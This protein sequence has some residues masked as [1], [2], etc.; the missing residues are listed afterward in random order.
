MGV[1]GGWGGMVGRRRGSE[2]GVP[3]GAAT[4][5]YSGRKAP[6]RTGVACR[7]GSPVLHLAAGH[8]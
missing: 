7:G 8:T 6:P 2:E 5:N 1:V 3:R 4:G